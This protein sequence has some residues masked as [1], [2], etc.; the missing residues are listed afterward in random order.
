M[1]IHLAAKVFNQ[2]SHKDPCFTVQISRF[3]RLILTYVD[4][5]RPICHRHPALSGCRPGRWKKAVPIDT[6]S[7]L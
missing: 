6:A 7:H 3:K 1:I 4:V 2:K 5:S